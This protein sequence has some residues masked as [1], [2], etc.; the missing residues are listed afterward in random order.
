M[1]KIFLFFTSLFICV[2]GALAAC[3]SV[4]TKQECTVINGGS[5][6]IGTI[7]LPVNVPTEVNPN[8]GTTQISYI[9]DQVASSCYVVTNCM[10]CKDGSKP[11]IKMLNKS[12]GLIGYY[13]CKCPACTDCESDLDWV[14]ISDGYQRKEVRECN[15][16]V[17][18]V[19]LTGYQCAPGYWGRTSDGETGCE[20]CPT[21][22]TS[23]AGSNSITECYIPADEVFPDTVGNYKFTSDCYYEE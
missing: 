12:C 8:C 7:L 22:G 6:G 1:R 16:G 14:T 21:G 23:N 2:D 4:A 10:D 20:P 19:V 18:N 5:G 9:Q 13:D 15:C 11:T 17:C 3:V